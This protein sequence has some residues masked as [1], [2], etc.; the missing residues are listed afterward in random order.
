M[1]DTSTKKPT[2]RNARNLR[3]TK[4]AA[5]PK[6]TTKNHMEAPIDALAAVAKD[7]QN[8]TVKGELRVRPSAKKS[9]RKSPKQK[10][11]MNQT[12][13]RAAP[14][15]GA[16]KP[17]TSGKAKPRSR[18]AKPAGK[19]RSFNTKP[20]ALDDSGIGI[21]AA[22]VKKVLIEEALNKSEHA[23]RELIEQYENKP[24]PPKLTPRE[25]KLRAENKF[26]KDELRARDEA[27]C[28]QQGNQ[29]PLGSLPPYAQTVLREA[30]KSYERSLREEYERQRVH[31]VKLED[32]TV[33]GGMSADEVAR[34]N[35]AKRDA[36]KVL[37]QQN[38][39]LDAQWKKK[40]QDGTQLDKRPEHAE[41]DVYAFNKSFDPKFYNRYDKW[42][43]EH[44]KHSL[45]LPK[46][47]EYS[48][49]L[50]LINKTLI[51]LSG[52]TRRIV[53]SF[54]DHMIEQ[55][56]ENAITNC[57]AENKRTLLLHHAIVQS[58]KFKERVPL[59]SWVSTF[60]YYEKSYMWVKECRRLREEKK[61]LKH[62]SGDDVELVLPQYS[63]S[64]IGYNFDNYVNDICRSVRMRLAVQQSNAKDREMYY[65]IGV[66]KDFKIFGSNII[67]EAI[68]RIGQ[69][70]RLTVEHDDVKTISDKMVMYVLSLVTTCCGVDFSSIRES[71]EARL[72]QF[73][74][75]T[76]ERKKRRSAKKSASKSD[77]DDDDEQ[78]EDDEDQ[79][80]EQ[81]EQ[82]EQEDQEEQDEDDEDQ[83]EE[84]DEQDP[85]YQD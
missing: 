58:E 77:A 13:R 9:P 28:P 30:Q 24:V 10:T 84:Q 47:T 26:T 51:R 17:R 32:G 73:E 55:Y 7:T 19:S 38:A 11:K 36:Q 62:E 2:Q 41:F 22:R 43:A 56:A 79:D 39:E 46:N 23:V 72:A 83:D 71:M 33:K 6:N 5:Q 8:M 1:A 59:G 70:L 16:G 20:S 15:K 4:P 18:S 35:D 21:G 57:L 31:G 42:V 12:V 34:Y 25:V 3:I 60:E 54:L 82:D 44:D 76:Q 81:D 49:A 37:R 68:I 48:R 27:R 66:S 67:N 45:H 52:Q 14:K 65:R 61:Q 69:C 53:A 63:R 78:D 85:E 74:R 40:S 50:S 75:W 29:I 80:E 64:T